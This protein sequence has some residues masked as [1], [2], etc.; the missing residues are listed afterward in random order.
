MSHATRLASHYE[1]TALTVAERKQ[2]TQMLMKLFEHWK[3]TYKQQA[4]VLGLSPNTE[5]SIHRYKNGK[6]YLP[7]FRDIQDRIQHL[8]TIHKYLRR[9]YPI[10]KNLA[11]QW[12][13]T[14]NMDFNRQSPLEMICQEGY[15]GLVKIKQYL[16]LHQLT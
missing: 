6:Q 15:M 11:Y 1:P 3:L 7:L 14:P 8:L 4:I 12:I 9:A 16:E 10:N 13:T 2:Q 5:T